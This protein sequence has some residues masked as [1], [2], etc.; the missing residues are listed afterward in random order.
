[1]TDDPVRRNSALRGAMIC[2][3]NICE[4]WLM[5]CILQFNGPELINSS[6]N[7]DYD[8]GLK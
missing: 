7:F 5:E 3:R 1:M 6:A 2:V 4:I 8:L